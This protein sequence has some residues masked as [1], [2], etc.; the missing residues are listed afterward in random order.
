MQNYRKLAG[1]VQSNTVT[2][3]VLAAVESSIEKADVDYL[4]KEIPIAVQ[5]SL[6]GVSHVSHIVHAMKEFSHPGSREKE[7]LDINHAIETTAIVARGEWKYVAEMETDLAPGLPPILCLVGE[8][9]Q[10]VLNLIVNAAHAIGDVVKHVEGSKGTI[11]I[12]SRLDGACGGNPDCGH[13]HG[14]SGGNPPPC[15]RTLSSPQR[16]LAGAPGQGLAIARSVIV[17]KH[18]GTLTFEIGKWAAGTTFIVRL[19]AGDAAA[20]EKVA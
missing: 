13:R 3:E 10:V 2:P 12:S 18:G 20:A 15:F 16:R 17:D 8:F 11:R 5:Q 6:Q 4:S 9:N 14:H 19:P 1:A 7:A